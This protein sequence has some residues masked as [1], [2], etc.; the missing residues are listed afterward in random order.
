VKEKF[1]IVGLWVGAAMLALIGPELAMVLPLGMGFVI[2]GAEL[3]L[4]GVGALAA[5]SLAGGATARTVT[6]PR[7][8]SVHA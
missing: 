2:G 8:R 7:S 6:R 1:S 5:T 4:G 3:L